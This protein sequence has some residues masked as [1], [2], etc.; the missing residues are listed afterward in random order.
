MTDAESLA[1]AFGEGA[2]AR[3]PYAFVECSVP[4]EGRQREAK[5]RWQSR[6][7]GAG[8]MDFAF[9]QLRALRA[10]AGGYAN[11]ALTGARRSAAFLPKES[12]IL[13]NRHNI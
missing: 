1:I 2:T 13:G 3:L 8:A 11:R 9:R 5:T 10:L 4:H 12:I 7:P 6:P